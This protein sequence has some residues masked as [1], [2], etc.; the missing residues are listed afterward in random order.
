MS[1]A[2]TLLEAAAPTPD[3]PGSALPLGG[4]LRA[5]LRR[6]RLRR[7]LV[8]AV[9]VYLVLMLA[10]MALS[11]FTSSAD[12]GIARAQAEEV[13]QQSLAECERSRPEPGEL[14]PGET[15]PPCT[16]LVPSAEEF[17]RFNDPRYRVV[18]QLP[19]DVQTSAGIFAVLAFVLG[20]SAI[21]AEWAAR[22]L[23][24][25][26]TW[27]PRRVRVLLVKLAALLIAVTGVAVLVQALTL[28][29]GWLTGTLRGTFEGV[30]AVPGGF[31]G[32]LLL[33]CG[34]GVVLAGLVAACAFAVTAVL[35]H[36]AA[37]L[38]L[39][40]GYFVFL[41][42]AVRA[43]RPHWEQWLLT[44]NVLG[45]L[46]RGGYSTQVLRPGAERDGNI[47]DTDYLTIVVTNG[48]AALYLFALTGAL[49]ALA[50]VVFRRR[51]LT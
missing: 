2:P 18:E 45:W 29:A 10:G 24:S 5:E 37:A 27:E 44:S 7:L 32:P 35:R 21:G 17:L 9:A 4:L 41:E 20:A 49:L 51:D 22:T 30:S 42:N 43:L 40:F 19:T 46:G 11:F 26:L 31:W 38:G 15:L 28:G 47:D 23:P 39:A 16:E 13:Y 50:L 25:L 3:A 6:L 36:T 1:T 14:P 33:Q 12:Q 34:R 8:L 48:E